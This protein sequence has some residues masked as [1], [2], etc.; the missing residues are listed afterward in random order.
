[1]RLLPA[2]S[3]AMALLSAP[4]FAEEEQQEDRQQEDKVI[5]KRSETAET[6]SRLS[7]PRKTCLKASEWKQLEDEKNR[8][9]SRARDISGL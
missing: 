5:C 8:T 3:V 1:M 7:R 2:V 6:G 9:V 4:A